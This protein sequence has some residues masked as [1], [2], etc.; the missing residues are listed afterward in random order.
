MDRNNFIQSS[1]TLRVLEKK[2]LSMANFSTMAEAENLEEDLRILNDSPYQ[3][4]VTKLKRPEDYEEALSNTLADGFEEL[5]RLSHDPLPVDLVTLKY[6]YHNLKVFITEELIGRNQSHLYIEVGGFKEEEFKS[7]FRGLNPKY[8]RYYKIIRDLLKRYDEHFD[9]QIIGIEID[10]YYFAHLRELAYGS[11][12]PLFREYVEDTIDFTNIKTI[13]RCQKQQRDVEFIEKA[14]IK[15]G[16]IPMDRYE[17]M[18]NVDLDSNSRIFMNSPI[19]KAVHDGIESYR[20]TGSLS[21]F[22]KEM[23]NYFMDLA[24]KVK[25]ITFGPEV[26]FGYALALDMEVKNLRTILIAKENRLEPDF[27]RERL[28]ESYV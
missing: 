15:H 1:A 12:V 9:P 25:N 14:L 18:L 16:G 11:G 22:E 23:D 7:G 2:L 20:E 4:Y 13:L 3:K 5:Y 28:R 26:V 10:Y 8:E 21:I 17:G 27:I 19:A 6:I 24:K